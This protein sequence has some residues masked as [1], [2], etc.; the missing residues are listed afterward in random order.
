MSEKYLLRYTLYLERIR[1]QTPITIR[2]KYEAENP[3]ITICKTLVVLHFLLGVKFEAKGSLNCLQNTGCLNTKCCF[4]F[5][6]CDDTI[7]TQRL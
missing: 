2:A 3:Q 5:D 4:Y 7:S 6:Y 1:I